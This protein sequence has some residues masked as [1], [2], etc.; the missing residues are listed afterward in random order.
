M[1]L[2]RPVQTVM[3]A[4]AAV[5]AS[6]DTMPRQCVTMSYANAPTFDPGTRND[7]PWRIPVGKGYAK[8]RREA[9]RRRRQ[10]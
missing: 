5:A 4:A 9:R 1:R 7:K 10:R 2:G 3:V 8:Q 6:F